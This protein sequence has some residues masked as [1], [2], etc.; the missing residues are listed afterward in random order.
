MTNLVAWIRKFVLRVQF[1]AISWLVAKL[2]QVKPVENDQSVMGSNF[3]TIKYNVNGG[4]RQIRVPFSSTYRTKM[5]GVDAKLI[6]TDGQKEDITQQPGIP[7]LSS[8]AS[9]GGTQIVL[10][11]Y[12]SGKNHVYGKDTIPGFGLEVLA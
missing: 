6:R 7:Y 10:S 5:I 1:I 11:N 3:V 8:A 4:I 12:D 9:L 2:T